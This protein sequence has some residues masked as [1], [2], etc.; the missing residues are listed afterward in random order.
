MHHNRDLEI[1]HKL[2]EQFGDKIDFFIR[3]EK[4]GGIVQLFVDPETAKNV[5]PIFKF[6]GVSYKDVTKKSWVDPL[7]KEEEKKK[8][9][10][11]GDTLDL[12]VH[13]SYSDAVEY[14]KYISSKHRDLVTLDEIGKSH[15]KRSIYSITIGYPSGKPKPII[16]IESGIHA[17]EWATQTSALLL[18]KYLI[19]KKDRYKDI[20]KKI[21]IVIVPN[22]N[23]D[24]YIY[25]RTVEKFWRCNR[26]VT[27]IHKK[28]V[29][30]NRNFAY[31]W[32][33]SWDTFETYPG[34]E[35]H[36]EAET[37][38]IIDYIYRNKKLIKGYLAL[39]SFGR[40][41][42]TPW[43]YMK[44]TYPSDYSD[45]YSLGEKMKKSVYDNVI[46]YDRSNNG[47]G[48]GYTLGTGADTLYESYGTSVDFAKWSG[49][50]YVYTI[51][52]FP[53]R[54]VDDLIGFHIK[55]E[56]VSKAWT[57]LKYLFIPFMKAIYQEKHYLRV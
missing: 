57:E 38:I 28:G 33:N 27:N 54:S 12:Y 14:L 3:E 32:K 35:P 20:Y 48:S 18:I 2:E 8:K 45:L 40:H 5:D 23:P 42:M 1:P 29:D 50:K 47:K 44:N 21:D 13:N 51:E 41:I 30:L 6:Y 55:N 26:N 22:I 25:S 46:K 36:S 16:F 17:R 49:V 19:E 10:F 53:H 15:E 43:N 34:S 39:H 7:E 37:K 9:Y 11:F 52:L 24:G 56:D 4:L 31:K